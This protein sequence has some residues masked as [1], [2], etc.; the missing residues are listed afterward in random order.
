MLIGPP[1]FRLIEWSAAYRCR[2]ARL[3]LSLQQ[4]H[5]LFYKMKM[6]RRYFLEW[7]Y[8]VNG[9]QQPT[10]RGAVKARKLGI[11]PSTLPMV[12]DMERL[13]VEETQPVY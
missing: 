11:R 13:R 4:L 9:K 3:A 10:M 7:H 12:G 2:A 5:W 1:H 6:V 8:P